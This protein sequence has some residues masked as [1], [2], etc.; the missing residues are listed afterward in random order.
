MKEFLSANKVFIGAVL[1]TLILLVGGV[2]LFTKNGST[3]DGN[4]ISNDILVPSGSNVTSGIVNGVYQPTSN[5]A[6]V[7]IVEFG[8]YECPACGA[9]QPLTKQLITEFAG[10][11]NYVFR[12]FPLSQH[13]N[14]NISSYGAEAAAL[15][16][17]FWQMHDKLYESQ[18][19][20]ATSPS[21]KD[22]I[23]GYAKDM[24]LNMAQ[25]NSDIDSQKV[26]DKVTRD[27]ND[28][29]LAGINATPTFYIN[30]VK[31]ENLPGS[32]AELKQL[33]QD[34][35]NNVPAPSGTPTAAYHIHFDLKV[36]LN[37]TAIDFTLPKY[38][39]GK[40]N[41]LDPNIHFHDGN[42]KVVHVHKENIPL[43]ELFDSFKLVIPDGTIAYVNGKKIDNILSYV[44]Q[45][46][47]QILIGSS[48][49]NTVSN[50]AC[51]YSLKCPARGTPPPEDC[52]GGLGTGCTE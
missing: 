6:A 33:V 49:L 47:D 23:V 3:T 11:I 22:I 16:G 50:D 44:P 19:D 30:G 14:A 24:G 28:G 35:L 52:V 7:T 42:G 43:K 36:Y 45:D 38:Q 10:K 25:F 32:Y 31:V 20:W 29:N 17:K 12:N 40:T 48:N 27:T 2:Y 46:L 41:V 39:D 34:A 5:N 21:A 8:D 26:K 51:I 13:A 1:G 9:Y 37:G 18:N 15:Q 4:K